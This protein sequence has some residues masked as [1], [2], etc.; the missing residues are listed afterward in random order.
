[1]TNRELYSIAHTRALIELLAAI[2]SHGHALA[3]IDG[4]EMRL[5]EPAIGREV[6]PLVENLVARVDEEIVIDRLA[7]RHDFDF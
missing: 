2:Q 4:E 7:P 6:T 3:L 5:S 1:M